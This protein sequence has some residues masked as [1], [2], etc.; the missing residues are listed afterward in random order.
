MDFSLPCTITFYRTGR[1]NPIV[2]GRSSQPMII[3]ERENDRFYW[4]SCGV[5]WADHVSRE[6]DPGCHWGAAWFYIIHVWLGVCYLPP[7]VW[8]I[9]VDFAWWRKKFSSRHPVNICVIITSKCRTIGYI[10]VLVH[11]MT[12]WLVQWAC[13]VAGLNPGF[14]PTR[15][16]GGN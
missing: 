5:S 8:S 10:M 9:W 1:L 4:L 2:H 7:L 12:P 13:W 11:H 3:D 14:E 16:G 15:G 6:L